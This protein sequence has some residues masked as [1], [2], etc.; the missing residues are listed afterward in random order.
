MIFLI[1][2]LPEFTFIWR[3]TKPL[4]GEIPSNLHIVDWLPQNDLLRETKKFNRGIQKYSE[5]PK[6]VAFV[7]HMGMNSFIESTFA[8]VPFLSIPLFADQVHNGKSWIE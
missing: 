5:S 7:S 3:Y 6:V 4:N 2:S 8:G 1:Q